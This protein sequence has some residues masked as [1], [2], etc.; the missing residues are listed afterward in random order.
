MEFDQ[1]F[2]LLSEITD[3]AIIAVVRAFASGGI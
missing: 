3:I 2:E 1:D